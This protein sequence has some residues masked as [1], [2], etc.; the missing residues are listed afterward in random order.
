MHIARKAYNELYSSAISIQT[1]MRG[2]AARCSLR[3]RKQTSAAIIIQVENMLKIII[4][5]HFRISVQSL[6]T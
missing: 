6:D 5:G 2:M 4:V 1:G 3:F